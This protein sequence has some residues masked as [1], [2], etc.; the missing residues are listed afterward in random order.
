MGAATILHFGIGERGV[1]VA[2]RYIARVAFLFFWLT[3][4]GGALSTLFGSS[5]AGL[6]RRRREL[7]LAFAA[8]LLVH[9]AFVA[10][11]FRIAA[12]QPISDMWI[13]YFALGAVCAYALAAGSLKRFGAV[14][15]TRVG[16]IFSTIAIE[17]IAFLFFRDFVLLPLQFGARHPLEYAPFALLI[18][19]GPLLRWSV[20]ARRWQITS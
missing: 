12:R 9:L 14:L 3:Y 11:L 5:F 20:M 8:A 19:V 15:H 7:G 6:G 1:S 4:T 16:R 10:W 17:Y 18:I 2:T 13:V